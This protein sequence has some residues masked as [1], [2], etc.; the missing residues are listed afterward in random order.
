MHNRLLAWSLTLL[1]AL[2]LL[3]SVVPA[4]ETPRA[5]RRS[6]V[7]FMYDAPA[8]Y[9]P[10]G[11]TVLGW[12]GPAQAERIE[13][14]HRQGVRLFATSVG[15][16]TEF[17]G[18][19]DFSPEFMDAA[20]RNFAGEPFIVPW[21]WDHEHKGQKAWWFCTNSPLYRQFLESRLV[22]RM[23]AG[24]DGLHIDDYTGT[25]STV[26]WLSG[27]FCRHC[28]AGFRD[29]LAEHVPKEKLAALGITD[30]AA[31]DYRQFLLA[32]GVKPED[33]QRR[34]ASL[35]LADEFLDFQVKAD[36]AYVAEYRRRAEQL[37]GKPLA[38]AVNSG[39]GDPL[40]LAIAP[41]LSYFCCE[42]SQQAAGLAVPTHPVSIYKLADG[43]DRPVTSTASGQDW[44]YVAEHKRPCLV[45]T[46]IALS[47]AFGHNFMAP[48]RQWCYTKEKGTHWYDGPTEE[49]AWLYRFVREQRPA[50]GRLRGRRA[51]GGGVRQRRASQGPRQH[52]AGV[53]GAGRAERPLHRRRGGR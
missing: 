20:C 39:L 38:L 21:L 25:A 35:P 46:W 23:K 9:E 44:A 13:A 22:E 48:H 8:A 5:I 43:L 18:M 51:G 24:P 11:C 33:Y 4:A 53:R 16:R 29:Y 6:D 3:A 15:F 41:E 26:T 19:I 2:G 45:R 32:K 36:T 1:S 50:V 30:L 10:Y 14:A 42:V 27:C 52:R 12:A 17:A 49:Y 31:F 7:V 47:Y 34:R 37:R 40:A 28:M